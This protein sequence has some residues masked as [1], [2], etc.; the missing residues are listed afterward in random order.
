M[1][2]PPHDIIDRASIYLSKMIFY[3]TIRHI[4]SMHPFTGQDL[5]ILTEINLIN[6]KK[7]CQHYVTIYVYTYIYS[8]WEWRRCLDTHSPST[9]AHLSNNK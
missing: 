1:V 6:N 8:W 5:V 9:F 7:H 2:D 4:A 3:A